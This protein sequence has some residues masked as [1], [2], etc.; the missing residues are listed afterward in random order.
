MSLTRFPARCL[1]DDD[2]LPMTVVCGR[3]GGHVGLDDAADP[4]LRRRS[5]IWSAKPKAKPAYPFVAIATDGDTVL[6][7]GGQ[8][9]AREF[10]ANL[11]AEERRRLILLTSREVEQ[12]LPVLVDFDA[13]A[14]ALERT[15]P[16]FDDIKYS[17]SLKDRLLNLE[18]KLRM[19]RGFGVRGSTLVGP[20]MEQAAYRVERKLRSK[21]GLDGFFARLSP[22]PYQEVFRLCEER[23]DRTVLAL[24]FNSMYGACMQGP[25][26]DPASLRYRDHRDEEYSGAC[27]GTG[28]YRVRLAGPVGDFIAS[29]HPFRIALYGD[30]YPFRL[31]NGTD[32]ET[33]VTDNELSFLARHFKSVRILESITSRNAIVHPLAH[34]ARRLYRDRMRAG[35]QGQRVRERIL[36]LQIAAL[37]S[38]T[39]KRRQR[40]M[41]FRTVEEC[42]AHIAGTFRLD[43]PATWA[44]GEQL[45]ALRRMGIASVVVGEG[46]V[47]ARIKDPH[48]PDSLHCLASR[49]IA[50][51]R[52]R[53]LQLLELLW[54]L[55]ADVCY[56]NA[57]SV[58][59]SVERHRVEAVLASL[60][61]LSGTGMGALRIQCVADA[62]FWFDP[63]RYWLFAGGEV[64]RFANKLFNH[65]GATDPF[66][67]RRR[68][69]TAYRGDVVGFTEDRYYAIENSFSYAKR[70]LPHRVD[71]AIYDRYPAAEVID[72]EVAG[73]SVRQEALNSKDVKVALFNRML[74]A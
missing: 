35:A 25:F 26:P 53:M 29:H 12:L 9:C 41:Q 14:I 42:L 49:V 1:R 55:G 72:L 3:Y 15:F 73:N 18:R 63:G 62:G 64:V 10:L 74:P 6:G 48:A 61:E 16:V 37:H 66:L 20:A 19:L 59:V 27:H 46:G 44:T 70:L 17:G 45:R 23:P 4:G 65:P 33:L 47:R 24:D 8:C 34:D 51:A 31:D 57:D 60:A 40:T 71:G 52:L 54:G 11:S 21:N 30:R 5:R 7:A 50:N 43:F 32:V 56:V 22:A 38:A 2:A 58:H 36:K 68:V 39:A 69:R 28:M 13:R 67:Q